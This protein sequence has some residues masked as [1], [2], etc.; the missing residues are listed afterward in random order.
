MRRLVVIAIAGI[1]IGIVV[2]YFIRSRS[3]DT[4]AAMA[5]A[6]AGALRQ[7]QGPGDDAG[8][9]APAPST[10]RVAT[11]PPTGKQRR[12]VCTELADR[13]I[14]R[15]QAARDAEPKDPAWAY[16]M[17]QK[18]REVTAREFQ[19]SEI[20][21]LSIDCKTNFCEITARGFAP[22]TSDEFG[23][24]M[25][26]LRE[27]PWNDFTGYSFVHDTDSAKGLHYAR[28][29][30]RQS[31]QTPP[32]E[33][34]DMQR[35]V[36]R[37][38]EQAMAACTAQIVERQDRE[39]AARDAEPRDSSWADPME[40]LLRQHITAQL[41]QHPV[42]TMEIACRAT[43]CMIRASGKT[44]DS[45]LAFQKV[46]QAAAEEPWSDVLASGYSGGSIGDDWQA[47]VTLQR[48]SANR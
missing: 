24:A 10:L 34:D 37:A 29:T 20:E 5:P 2:A 17:E 36:L 28:F 30:R 19:A 44:M 43:F 26:A 47:E 12:D 25:N 16:P 45:Q 6:P 33:L 31:K 18:L 4:Q 7:S 39:R 42:A 40:Q 3:V 35:A 15:E 1:A 38:E 14:A 32:A 9:A 48:R 23:K 13:R 21:V 11:E 41:V 27:Q 22:Q 46:S 8:T